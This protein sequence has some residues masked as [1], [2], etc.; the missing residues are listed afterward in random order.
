MAKIQI[1]PQDKLMLTVAEACALFSTGRQQMEEWAKE[2]D[3][4][5]IK[6]GRERRIHR[7]KLNEWFGNKCDVRMGE[8][9]YNRSLLQLGGEL[10]DL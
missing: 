3:F 7:D 8:K 5:S 9:V 6:V 1:A 4:P 2:P 10:I